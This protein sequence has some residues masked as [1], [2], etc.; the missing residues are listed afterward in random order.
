MEE[1]LYWLGFSLFPGIGPKRFNIL[2]NNFKNAKAAWNAKLSD[3]EPILGKVITIKFDEFRRNFIPEKYY[4][5]LQEKK[6]S[7]TTL[8]D[9]DYPDLLKQIDDPPFL[10][11]IKGRSDIIRETY[12]NSCK[13]TTPELAV[14]V[15]GTRK[16]TAYGME[17]TTKLT[18]DLVTSGFIIV[19][20]LAFGVDTCAHNTTIKNRGKTIAVLGCGVDCCNPREN[21][22]LYDEICANGGAIISELPPGAAPTKGSFPSRNR[23][24]AGLSHGVLVTEGSEVSGAL[25]TAKYAIKYGRPVFAIPGPITSQLSKGPNTLITKGAKLV[26]NAQDILKEFGIKNNDLRSRNK[27]IKGETEEEQII[28]NYLYNENLLFDELVQKTKINSS[29]LSTLLSVM[30]IRG[31]LTSSQGLYSLIH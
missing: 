16:I 7:F 8:L 9:Q 19:S 27:V 18:A 21:Q 6:V 29:K 4:K 10:L 3:L 17:V 13:N 24:I 25:Y 14:A 26:L 22:R 23:I 30:E 12:G 28:I 5:K 2:L 1:K 20:G 11:Y 15:V 31:L